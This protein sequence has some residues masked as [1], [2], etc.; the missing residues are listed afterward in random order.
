MKP[1]LS[2]F[3]TG[4]SIGCGVAV[5]G[6]VAVVAAILV[7]VGPPHLKDQEIEKRLSEHEADYFGLIETSMADDIRFLGIPNRIG[8]F[9]SEEKIRFDK[10]P[11]GPVV[12]QPMELTADKKD[13]YFAEMK[14]L[15]IRGLLVE[16]DGTYLFTMSSIG[17]A[18]GATRKGLAFSLNSKS[19][20]LPSLDGKNLRPTGRRCQQ[21]FK[22]LWGHWYVYF[23]N[24]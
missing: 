17:F 4:L 3:W 1:K 21:V 5:F 16:R 10:G 15:G 18:G 7:Y 8:V 6:C 22:K 13:W 12:I 23:T 14:R 11:F 24:C 2:V 9:D 19:P 20:L